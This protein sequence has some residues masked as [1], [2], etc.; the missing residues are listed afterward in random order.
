MCSRGNGDDGD[1]GDDGDGGASDDDDG[2][3]E[4]FLFCKI[5]R[6]L[7]YHNHAT[8]RRCPSTYKKG[9]NGTATHHTDV[10]KDLTPKIRQVGKIS[11]L[12]SATPKRRNTL[13]NSP[14]LLLDHRIPLYLC[15]DT[16]RLP[17]LRCIIRR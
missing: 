13:P 17:V 16:C 9:C 12:R 2:D 3:D 6:G 11:S 10:H 4:V 15:G 1:D 14:L 5:A 8:K 7:N